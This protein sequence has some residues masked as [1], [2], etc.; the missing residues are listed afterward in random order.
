LKV[1]AKTRKLIMAG[2]TSRKQVN[3][4]FGFMIE[5]NNEIENSVIKK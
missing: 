4:S 1:K 3:P 5:A 2:I